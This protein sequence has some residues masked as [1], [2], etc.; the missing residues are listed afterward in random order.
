MN[1][2]ILNSCGVGCLLLGGVSERKK[3]RKKEMGRVISL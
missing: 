1:A 2:D 3:E